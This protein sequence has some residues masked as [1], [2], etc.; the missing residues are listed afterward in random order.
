MHRHGLIAL[1][2][3]L[4]VAGGTGTGVA[5]AAHHHHHRQALKGSV[6]HAHVKVVHL[7][8]K[9]GRG[10]GGDPGDDYPAELKNAAQ[11]SR[12]D[13]WLEYN[14][15]CTSFVA[16]ALHSRNGF[17]M[18]FHDNANK[19]GPRAAAAGFAVNRTPAVGSVAWS[20]AGTYGHVAYVVAVNG[21]NVTVEEYNRDYH[22]HYSKREV[23]AASF[24]GYIHFA[25]TPAEPDPTPVVTP[26]PAPAPGTW[27]EQETPNHPVNTFKNP[28][29]ASDQGPAIPAGASVQVSCKLYDPTIES[30]KPDGYWYR[31]QSAPW[32][33]AY[34]APANTFM[35]G[36]PAGGPYTHNV[37]SAVKDC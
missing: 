7:N 14:R 11:D 24:T 19:W 8:M 16:W 27:T 5:D 28:H 2:A 35:N 31:I 3:A 32:S 18:P 1:A 9:G 26:P 15:E 22:G 4:L 21:A 6:K 12:L 25:D 33:D 13:P 23:S 34:Y 37:D 29:N 20:N 17:D 10:G 36:D 30:V